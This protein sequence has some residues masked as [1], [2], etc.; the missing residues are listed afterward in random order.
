M[1]N[2]KSLLHATRV[3]IKSTL[4]GMVPTE[5]LEEKVNLQLEEELCKRVV[6]SLGKMTQLRYYGNTRRPETVGI[7]RAAMLTLMTHLDEEA[8]VARTNLIASQSA[9]SGVDN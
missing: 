1:S 3:Q 7:A 8:A 4:A 6:E 9:Q 2:E 5:E